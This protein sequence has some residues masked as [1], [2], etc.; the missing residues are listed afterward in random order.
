MGRAFENGSPLSCGPGIPHA[1]GNPVPEPYASVNQVAALL[2]LHPYTV[3][4][5][6]ERGQLP[7]SFK[8]G[9]SWRIPS[10]AI[11]ALERGGQPIPAESREKPSGLR[12]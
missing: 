9:K 8:M 2:Q 4:R 6:I 5:M 12:L 10:A 1:R 3:R 11:E 7:G